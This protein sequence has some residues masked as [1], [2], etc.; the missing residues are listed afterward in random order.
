MGTFCPNVKIY[1]HTL[2]YNIV[3]YL[4]R[5]MDLWRCTLAFLLMVICSFFLVR[6]HQ[7]YSLF[8]EPSLALL[9]Y[10]RTC[11][12]SIST[13]SSLLFVIFFFLFYF[14][15]FFCFFFYILAMDARP[16]K[17]KFLIHGK[18]VCIKS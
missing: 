12:F 2:V 1:G 11:L 10:C 14:A 5:C 3:C 16:Y 15:G 6:A 7:F 4:L 18:K 17:N 8:K 13:Y 9:F